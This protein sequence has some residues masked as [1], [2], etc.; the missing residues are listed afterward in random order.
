MNVERFMEA[1]AEFDLARHHV[2]L[3][4]VVRPAIDILRTNSSQTLAGSRFGG[5]PDLPPS[6]PWPTHQWGPYWFLAQINFAEIPSGEHRLASSGLLSLFYVDDPELAH[7]YDDHNYVIAQFTSAETKVAPRS[8]P[9]SVK[10][11]GV[12]SITFRQTIDI[13]F[14]EYQRDDWPFSPEE[15][16]MYF[17]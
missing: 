16:D 8:S 15:R 10:S 11:R 6:A 1:V 5:S 12:A 9:E 17:Q 13:P 4:E 7:F 3:R 2:Y 14:D